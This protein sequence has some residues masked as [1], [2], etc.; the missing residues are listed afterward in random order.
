MN[1]RKIIFWIHLA[2]GIVSG[3]I[4]GALCATGAALA[5]EHEV[6]AWAERDITRIAPPQPDSQPLEIDELL[7]RAKEQLAPEVATSLSAIVAQKDPNTVWKIQLGRRDFR[8]L[9]PYTGELFESPATGT[10]QFFR[11]MFAWHRWLTTSQE[12]RSTGKAI[13]GIANLSFIGLGLT[14]LYLWFP[15]VW[16]WR[17]FRSVLLLKTSAKGKARDFNWHNV[18][19]FWALIP[20]LIMAITGTV[21]SYG[22]ARDLATDLLGPSRSRAPVEQTSETDA[23]QRG[24]PLSLESRYQIA[25]SWNQNWESITLPASSS[26]QGRGGERQGGAAGGQGRRGGQ[27]AGE[28]GHSHGGGGGHSHGSVEGQNRGGGGGG[29]NRGGG[30]GASGQTI[31][32]DL[33]GDWFPLSPSRILIDPR[34][35][36]ILGEDRSSEWPF[37]AKLRSSIKAIHTGEAGLLPGKIIAFLG[38]LAGVLLVYTGFALSYRRFFR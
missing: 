27:G 12:H 5:F 23:P 1:F 6:I 29:G 10:R 15:K 7:S 18:F 25:Q 20:I 2:F 9:N 4:I 11:T 22:W 19:G 16:K 28:G 38:C 32:I 30:G 3:L 13:T 21:F 17:I 35:G 26:R 8:Y 37:A 14:G 24:R 33:A 31:S 36:A 34:S